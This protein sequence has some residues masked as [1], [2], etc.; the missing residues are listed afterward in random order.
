MGRAA[1]MAQ[2]ADLVLHFRPAKTPATN[3]GSVVTGIPSSEV[4]SI[5]SSVS[6]VGSEQTASQPNGAVADRAH[7]RSF[8][9]N[10]DSGG[11]IT[12]TRSQQSRSETHKPISVLPVP[13]AITS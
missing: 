1:V 9:L 8:W 7:S 3:S 4:R 6:T 12:R 13:Q 5:R 11:T 10:S 2:S